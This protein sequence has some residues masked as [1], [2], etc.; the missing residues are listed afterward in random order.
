[1]FDKAASASA[2]MG[3]KTLG[4]Q[5]LC[6]ASNPWPKEVWLEAQCYPVSKLKLAWHVRICREMLYRAVLI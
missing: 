4:S 3:W 5:E 1:M 2:Q 6:S